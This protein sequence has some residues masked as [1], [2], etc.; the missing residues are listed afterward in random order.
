LL[1]LCGLKE[2]LVNP[3][4]PIQNPFR[5]IVVRYLFHFLISNIC[6]YIIY[7]Y[8]IYIYYI[9]IFLFIYIYISIQYICT[10]YIYNYL[11]I[12][13]Q[14]DLDTTI[15]QGTGFLHSLLGKAP[16]E[17][18]RHFPR[19]QLEGTHQIASKASQHGGL[20][21]GRPTKAME[22]L[23]QKPWNMWFSP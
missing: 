23:V 13:S 18:K 19:G 2:D 11:Y 21:G 17:A 14:P 7:V 3:Y 6:I 16:V 8:I 22:K 15:A 9:Y 12:F 20:A 4:K 5:Y 1:G 10:V